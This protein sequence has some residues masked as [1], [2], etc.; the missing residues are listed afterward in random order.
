MLPNEVVGGGFA[1]VLPPS[2]LAHDAAVA[3]HAVRDD[4]RLSFVLDA[5]GSP[6]DHTILLAT[7]RL[8]N[9]LSPPL[10]LSP[11]IPVHNAREIRPG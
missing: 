1:Y 9:D 6:N 8:T 11:Y 10:S 7:Q 5:A 2:F 3:S 4:G